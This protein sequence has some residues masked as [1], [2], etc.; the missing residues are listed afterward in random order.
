MN[1]KSKLGQFYTTNYEYILNNMYIPEDINCI[2]E[3]FA[4]NGD[5]LH[6]INDSTKYTIECY[7]IEPKKTSILKKDTLQ[8]PPCYD[9]KF[10]LTNPPYLAR[11]KNKDKELYDKY[12]CNDLYKC[13]LI[14]VINSNCEG[15]IIIIPLN[16]I[17]S[18]RKNDIELRK[19]FLNKFNIILL[20]IFEEKV[21]DDT[22]YTVCSLQFEKKVDLA[23]EITCWIYPSNKNF[24]ILLTNINNYTIGGE[25]Y[26]LPYSTVYKIERATKLTKQKE[27]ITNILLKCIDDN[28]ESKIK[29]KIVKD[30]E[31]FIDDTKNLSARSYATLVIIPEIDITKQK[32]LVEKFNEY[33]EINR[34]KFYSLFLSNYRE[35]NSIARKRIS[36]DLAFQICSYLLE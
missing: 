16:F 33:L 25:I 11:N 2:I 1:I 21:F 20:N 9:N 4:G 18:I 12:D 8:E 7:D 17:S 27:C 31:R 6:F 10:I 19:K 35:S 13:F 15:G 36:F 23:K 34:N 29:L 22:T 26:N 24:T 5:L 30:E 14:Q 28:I 32:I 3:P